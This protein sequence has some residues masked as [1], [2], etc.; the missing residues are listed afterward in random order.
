M[1]E[2]LTNPYIFKHIYK[3]LSYKDLMKLRPVNNTVITSVDFFWKYLIQLY[4]RKYVSTC[5][6][7]IIK[8]LVFSHKCKKINNYKQALFN[9]VE[10]MFYE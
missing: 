6:P 3:Y 4:P 2:I 9:N 7:Y 5:P 10:Q 8:T 1:D